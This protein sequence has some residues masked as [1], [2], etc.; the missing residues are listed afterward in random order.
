MIYIG[1]DH[2]GFELAK[3]LE[4]ALNNQGHKASNLSITSDSNNDYVDEAIKVTK[5]L[6]DND[7]GIL[8]CGTGI[9]MSIA[10]NKVKGIKAAKCDNVDEAKL[11]KQHNN[12]NVICFSSKKS[13]DEIF[14]MAKIF[15]ET[16]F[17][18]EERHIRRINKIMDLEK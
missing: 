5:A 4:I 1:A 11:C 10:A 6:T 14:A 17:S 18:F 15:I 16:P 8:I 2:N 9:G 12:A 7:L 3:N 13:F